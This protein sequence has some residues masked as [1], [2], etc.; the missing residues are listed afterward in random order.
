[1]VSLIKN[2]KHMVRK[3]KDV[4][5]MKPHRGLRSVVEFTS[6]LHPKKFWNLEISNILQMEN[7]WE[8]EVNRWVSTYVSGC[9]WWKP[10]LQ[11]GQIHFAIWTNTL[12]IAKK[13]ILQFRQ[14][15]I[16]TMWG[17]WLLVL[18]METIVARF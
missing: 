3:I 12:E 4:S 9:R 18:L 11:F 2:W 16:T 6:I 7:S 1:M 5:K 14:I 15:W 10:L 17:E 13:Y 8:K